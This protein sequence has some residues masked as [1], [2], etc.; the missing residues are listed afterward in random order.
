ME[1]VALLF[2]SLSLLF[3]LKNYIKKNYQRILVD[4]ILSGAIF[5]LAILTTPRSSFLYLLFVV[6]LF[7]IFLKG[8]QTNNFKLIS[9][10]V[11]HIFLSFGLPYFIW[12]HPHLGDPFEI[13]NY[14]TPAA[15]TQISFNNNHID[16]NSFV[17]VLIDAGLLI[18][19]ILKKVKL[20]DYVYGFLFSSIIFISAVI[21]WS[22]HHGIIIPVLIFTALL[23]LFFLRHA[24]LSPFVSNLLLMIFSIQLYFIAIKYTVIWMDLPS[25]NSKAL[26]KIIQEYIPEK[27]RVMGSYN[28][29]YACIN[30]KCE[31]RSIE[32][33]TNIATGK[34]VPIIKK[35]DYLMNNYKDE[36]IVVY[37][38]EKD[39][40]KPFLEI[41]KFTKIASIAI[42]EAKE[43][44]W[45]K[46]RRILGLPG[47]TFYN[48]SIYKRINSN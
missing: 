19:A 37:N 2:I 30:N 5:C 8:M 47:Y 15:K 22:Y 11:I 40:L 13:F 34:P 46:G 23:I 18:F 3:L 45:E 31:F 29:Y 35:I 24:I 7:K 39:E 27:S 25:R 32:D 16:I 44:F 21:P 1:M 12:Y 42:P 20:P 6:P 38:S 36:Y 48:G 10:P 41:N 28:Y 17:W 9:I 43:T 33:N 14:I 4:G 26:Q